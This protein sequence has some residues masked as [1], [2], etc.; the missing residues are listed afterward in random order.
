[1]LRR[2]LSFSTLAATSR[3]LSLPRRTASTTP[4]APQRRSR[5]ASRPSRAAGATAACSW[6]TCSATAPRFCTWRSCAESGRS[7]DVSPAAEAHVRRDRDA[8]PHRRTADAAEQ[9]AEERARE[10]DVLGLR[11]EH[12]SRLLLQTREAVGAEDAARRPDAAHALGNRGLAL[13]AAD[14]G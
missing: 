6:N 3:Y 5:V 7:I 13:E 14:R 9:R 10:V 4:G 2:V 1:M 11:G 8:P 12:P